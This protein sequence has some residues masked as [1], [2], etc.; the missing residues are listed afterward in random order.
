MRDILL[1]FL[2]IVIIVVFI[3]F[4]VFLLNKYIKKNGVIKDYYSPW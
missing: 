3:F 2:S 1:A 4:V